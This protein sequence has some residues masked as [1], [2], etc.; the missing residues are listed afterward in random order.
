[1]F[2]E[3][4]IRN[5]A[6][7]YDFTIRKTG[8]TVKLTDSWG[9]SL[10][11]INKQSALSIM[12]VYRNEPLTSPV[13]EVGEVESKNRLRVAASSSESAKREYRSRMRLSA[14]NVALTAKKIKR[15]EGK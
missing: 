5:Y 7:R 10:E 2:D 8:M 14:P 3:K 15:R 13:Y 12:M 4:H 11:C 1:V 6:A 9:N